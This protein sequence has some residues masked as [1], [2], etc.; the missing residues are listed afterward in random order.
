MRASAVLLTL[1]ATCTGTFNNT[2]TLKQNIDKFSPLLINL[3]FCFSLDY[4]LG[5]LLAKTSSAFQTIAWVDSETRN[6]KSLDRVLKSQQ[7]VN[8]DIKS[9]SKDVLH[10]NNSLKRVTMPTIMILDD[11]GGDKLDTMLKITLGWQ[12]HVIIVIGSNGTLSSQD[13][14][15]TMPPIIHIQQVSQ[16]NQVKLNFNQLLILSFYIQ[17]TLYLQVDAKVDVFC[18]KVGKPKRTTKENLATCL[19]KYKCSFSATF[20]NIANLG[21]LCQD[22]FGG[23]LVTFQALPVVPL[24]LLPSLAGK[25]SGYSINLFLLYARK[26]RFRPKIEFVRTTG[27]YL[28][29]NQTFSPGSFLKVLKIVYQ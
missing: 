28:P 10:K 21:Q 17:N 26:Y 11:N 3:V 7:A 16:D 27:R 8:V 15:F 24:V 25:L 18:P 5:Q 14:P 4:L 1:I 23:Q 20:H 6:Y 2:G 19:D 29:H 22:P 9:P 13:L 12:N